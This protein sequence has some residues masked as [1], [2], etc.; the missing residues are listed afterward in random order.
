MNKSTVTLGIIL[1][2]SV[3]DPSF[4]S[5]IFYTIEVDDD[6]QPTIY[7]GIVPQPYPRDYYESVGAKLLPFPPG[8]IVNVGISRSG[9]TE[10]VTITSIEMIDAGP[11][12][13]TP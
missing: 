3:D 4:A 8:T 11:C 13:G 7:E 2:S 9:S 1:A 12:E 5:E 6:G 10:L